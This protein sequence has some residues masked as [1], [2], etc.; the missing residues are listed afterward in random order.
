M[1]DHMGHRANG[2]MDLQR[3]EKLREMRAQGRKERY[4]LLSDMWVPCLK[5]EE[6]Q[7][8]RVHLLYYM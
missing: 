7:F 4:F 3:E 2:Q 5:E 8:A 6:S 1:A